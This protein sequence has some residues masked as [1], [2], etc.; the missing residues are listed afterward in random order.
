MLSPRCAMRGLPHA[1]CFALLF[2]ASGRADGPIQDPYGSPQIDRDCS[3]ALA[4]EAC[5]RTRIALASRVGAAELDFPTPAGQVVRG[6]GTTLHPLA[7]I[8]PLRRYTFALELPLATLRLTPDE[9]D[10]ERQF[11]WGNPA[12]SV[13][14]AEPLWTS[15][16]RNFLATMG[17]VLTIPVA[18]NTAAHAARAGRAQALARALDGH[19]RPF[20]FLPGYVTVSP[21]LGLEHRIRRYGAT[22]QLDLPVAFR[23]T[24]TGLGDTATRQVVLT[25]VLNATGRL[26]ATHWLE[27]S[28]FTSGVFGAPPPLSVD[29]PARAFQLTMEPA[30][31]ARTRNLIATAGVAV[32]LGGD[33]GQKMIS[34]QLQLTVRW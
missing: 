11:T 19:R 6:Y 18:Q 32:P 33:L 20:L 29:K 5:P 26:Q 7:A 23:V 27:L 30:V 9:G 16:T 13:R 21:S 4:S 25:P 17:L 24:D 28:L 10:D 12:L 34:G 14:R 22:L 2:A 1:L 8:S 15:R 3:V 31:S